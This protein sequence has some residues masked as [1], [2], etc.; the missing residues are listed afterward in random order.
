MKLLVNVQRQKI[1]GQCGEIIHILQE[2]WPKHENV[3]GPLVVTLKEFLDSFTENENE[4]VQGLSESYRRDVREGAILPKIFPSLYEGVDE[5][6]NKKIRMAVAMEKFISEVE[7]A[8]P[9]E[10]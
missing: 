6:K 7:V 2:E 8:M 5:D 9:W 10:N 1:Y 4:E 3:E